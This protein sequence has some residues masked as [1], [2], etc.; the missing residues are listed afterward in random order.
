MVD[1][2]VSVLLSSHGLAELERVADYLVMLPG[3]QLRLAGEADDLKREILTVG[4]ASWRSART[5]TTVRMR[6]AKRSDAAG[7]LLT[8]KPWRRTKQSRGGADDNRFSAG[9]ARRIRCLLGR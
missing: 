2:G 3:G 5:A 6:M 9:S 7:A 8:K 4:R 1:D